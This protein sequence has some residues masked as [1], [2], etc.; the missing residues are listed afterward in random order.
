MQQCTTAAVA[1][2]VPPLVSDAMLVQHRARKIAEREGVQVGP[3]Q[4]AALS[5]YVS[6]GF[7]A[8]GAVR[9]ASTAALGLAILTG[10]A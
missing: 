10:R 2:Q 4:E 3:V 5:Y 7:N 9:A 6:S 1:P 8:L